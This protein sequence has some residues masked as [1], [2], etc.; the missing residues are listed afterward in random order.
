M[1]GSGWVGWG[2]VF[3]PRDVT[4]VPLMTSRSVAAEAGQP[5]FQ[6]S[7]W[8]E[9][10]PTSI[11]VAALAAGVVQRLLVVEDQLGE[12]GQSVAIRESGRAH[13]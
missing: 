6:A 1:L 3:A 8:I 9:P 13:C 12:G 10:R 4:V 7:G 11:R 5:V 2:V